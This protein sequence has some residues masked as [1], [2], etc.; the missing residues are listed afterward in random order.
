[1]GAVNITNFGGMLPI[2]DDRRL[3]ETRAA[4]AE[5]VWLHGGILDG[6][7]PNVLV[8]TCANPLTKS[9]FRIP[10]D[11]AD[12]P[13]VSFLN[14]T[15]MEF[16]NTYVDVHRTPVVDDQYSRYYWAQPGVAPQY[17]TFARIQSASPDY[18]LG[19]PAPA[20]APTV[21]AT[22]LPPVVALTT[23]EAQIEM[24]YVAYLGRGA[25]PAGL[26][27]WANKLTTGSTLTQVAREIAATEEARVKYSFLTANT[28]GGQTARLN[29]ITLIYQTLFGRAPDGTATTGGLGFWEVVLAGYQSTLVGT[30]LDDAVNAFILEIAT[31]ATNSVAGNDV[32]ALTNKV[33]VATYFT[34]RLAV[35]NLAYNTAAA[36][37][38]VAVVTATTSVAGTVITQKAQVDLYASIGSTTT[39]L[40]TSTVVTVVR[41]YLYTWVTTYGEEGP[42]SPATLVTCPENSSQ[43]ITL[44]SPTPT[45]TTSRSLATTRIYRTITSSAGIATYFLVAEQAIGTLTYVDVLT[46][47]ELSANNQLESTNWIGP[48][49]GLEGMVA[50]AN[51]IFAGWV[52]NSLYFSEPYRPHAW[53]AAYSVTVDYPIVGLGVIGQTLV[54]CTTGHPATCTGIHP[55]NMTLSK[56]QVA[57][58]CT[59]RGSIVSRPGGVYYASPNGIVAAAAGSIKCITS[60]LIDKTEWLNDVDPYDLI[61]VGYGTAYLALHAPRSVAGTGIMIDGGTL[62]FQ[63]IADSLAT[64]KIQMDMWSSEIFLVTGAAVY[65]FDPFEAEEREV[66]TWKSK[67]FHNARINNLGAMKVYFTIPSGTATQNPV[68]DNT[69][70][71]TLSSDQYALIKVY[72]DGSHVATRE[73]RTSGELIRLP[74]GF[75]AEYWQF[76]ITSRVTITDLTVASTSRELVNA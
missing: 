31:A 1:M 70:V 65:R 59:S 33:T 34:Q 27:Y 32:N 14:S 58:P 15:W 73:V 53:P 3:P 4:F 75:K 47:D 35:G 36:A 76:E 39:E 40:T 30:A 23:P 20:T 38:A 54:V 7:R 44:T 48:P 51:G 2:A 72:A 49:S 10:N 22:P 68:V 71:Q 28:V 17:N 64:K 24:L 5:N 41:A 16:T 62:G 56:T 29:F 67:I 69:L 45:D 26:Q 46:D 43:T 9:I 66:L 21:A 18:V 8:H 61:A 60:E 12:R 55:A 52:G 13:S 37:E 6:F 74:S 25:D 42:P 50:M 57:E 11:F 19:V 63:W